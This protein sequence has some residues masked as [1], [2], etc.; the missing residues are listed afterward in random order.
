VVALVKIWKLQCCYTAAAVRVQA[1]SMGHTTLSIDTYLCSQH[2]NNSTDTRVGT[3]I[4]D[5]GTMQ[6]DRSLAWWSLPDS[7]AVATET[8]RDKTSDDETTRE[9][10]LL[11]QSQAQTQTDA[12]MVLLSLTRSFMRETDVS[13]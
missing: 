2:R 7:D 8:G 12:S 13:A 5:A 1:T 10:A 9:A 4:I 11:S 3:G 6:I